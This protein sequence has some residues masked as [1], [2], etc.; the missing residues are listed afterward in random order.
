MRL[1]GCRHE[2]RTWQRQANRACPIKSLFPIECGNSEQQNC[3]LYQTVA[4]VS[5]GV[6]K[7]SYG[8]CIQCAYNFVRCALRWSWMNSLSDLP[9][10][11]IQQ[12]HLHKRELMRKSFRQTEFFRVRIYTASYLR[13]R[14]SFSVESREVVVESFMLLLY[15]IGD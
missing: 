9:P 4:T 14:N 2:R 3:T 7:K 1:L 6:F 8:I 5:C 15:T 10:P 13:E 12:Y 11:T